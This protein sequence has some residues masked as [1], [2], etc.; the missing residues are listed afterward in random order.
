MAS[1]R[2]KLALLSVSDKSG[3]AEFAKRLATA[4]VELLSTGGTRRLLEEAGLAVRDVAH[5][6]GYPEMMD[7]RVKTLHPRVHGGLL[8]RRDNTQD[9][10]A[11]TE[12]GIEP[13]DLVVVNLYPFAQTIARG[14][15]AIE[16]AIEQIDIG[17]PSMVRSAAKNHEYVT[18]A[19]NAHQYDQIA[20]AIEKEGCTSLELR[21]ELA[22]AAF[23]HTA[24]YDQAIASYFAQQQESDTETSFPAQLDASFTRRATLRYGENP[25]QQAALYAKSD[26]APGALVHGE[27]LHGKELSYNNWLDLDAAWACARSL[28]K[29]GVAVLKHNNPCGAATGTSLGE[30]TRRAW[31]GDPVSAFGSILG[32]NQPVDA[33][34]A[35]CLAEPGKFV[36]AIAAPGFTNEAVEILTTKPKWK[37]N[38]RLVQIDETSRE[39]GDLILRSIDGGALAQFYLATSHFALGDYPA[40]LASYE[41]AARAGYDNDSCMLGRAETLRYSDQPDDA[42]A[43]L[44]ALS[45][46]VEQTAEYL[47]QRGATVAKL[48]G[49]REE[50][51]ALYGRAVEADE[52]HPGAL[53][54]LALENDRRGNDLEALQ[55]YERS[56]ARIP[57]HVGSLLNLGLMY[58]DMGRYENATICYQRILEIHP[59]HPRARLFFKDAD[60]SRDMLYDEDAQRRHDRLAQLLNV[61]V[62]D[63]ELSVRSRNCLQKMGIH[64][65]GD[66]TRASEQE[67]LNSK[68]FGETSLVEIREMLAAKG[69]SLG[70]FAHQRVD[71]APAYDPESLSPD[72]KALL[73]RPISDLNL[74]VRARKCM[75]RLGLTTIGELVRRTGDDLLE[76]K[77]FGVTSLNEVREKLT[78]LN[79]KLRGD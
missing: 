59:S 46:A 21:R 61:S 7:G 67:L 41:S 53:F 77:N 10:A 2:I 24:S 45:G 16:E 38:V 48:G 1:P 9:M 50:V 40:A 78:R 20:E 37:A 65:L 34:A 39:P 42:L 27:Q 8:C 72:E 62:A 4:G 22:G 11:A 68:N 76:C 6:T 13:I 54:G 35:E 15:V 5:Y 25:H 63:F 28:P 70:Q 36:E 23:A 79:L 55:L 26:A 44:D 66:L 17:G 57:A 71:E 73:D 60:A 18:V 75:V 29:P 69:L 56:T 30:A 19:S 32:F 14:D 51:S 64:T 31:E 47:Y 33:A 74:S 3:L 52:Q 43:T 12:H 49:S 58:E